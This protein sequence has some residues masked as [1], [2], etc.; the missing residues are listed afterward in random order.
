MKRGHD[1]TISGPHRQ[2]H[3]QAVYLSS[4][5]SPMYDVLIRNA[6]VI[7][8]TGK[9][10][11]QADVAIKDGRIAAIGARLDGE[12]AET[13]DAAGLVL[14][15]GFIDPHTHSDLTLLI[16]PLAQSKI[17][18]GVTTEVIGNCGSA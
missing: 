1:A 8:G 11:F 2:T 9:A 5:R 14:S 13:L 3:R 4:R 18:Q 12:T 10:G 15:P 6:H 16:D 7:D 17:R